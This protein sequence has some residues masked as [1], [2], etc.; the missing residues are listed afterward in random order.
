M[1]TDD[2]AKR[3]ECSKTRVNPHQQRIVSQEESGKQ[4]WS[5]VHVLMNVFRGGGRRRRPER[6]RGVKLSRTNAERLAAKGW[7]GPIGE[8]NFSTP[9]V[10][11]HGNQ[12]IRTLKDKGEK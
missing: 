3:T 2:V 11:D 7:L 6:E 8:G 10:V 9:Y 5:R 12:C 1:T 4:T